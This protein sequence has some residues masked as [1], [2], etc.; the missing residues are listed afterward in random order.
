MNV[1]KLELVY[2]GCRLAERGRSSFGMLPGSFVQVVAGT[3]VPLFRI[4]QGSGH[5]QSPAGG[6][7][8]IRR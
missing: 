2:G 6:N 8:I 1:I 3:F 4:D 7:D 5:T